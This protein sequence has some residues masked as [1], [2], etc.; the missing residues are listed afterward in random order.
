V[1]DGL[2]EVAVWYRRSFGAV[3]G[4]QWAATPSMQ[5]LPRAVHHTIAAG[6]YRDVDMVNAQPTLLAQYCERHGIPAPTLA[7]YASSR[8]TMLADLG[9][10]R[11]IGKRAVIALLN[12]GTRDV[13][14]LPR[15]PEW[16]RALKAEVAVIHNAMIAET[17]HR[18]VVAAARAR[19]AARGSGN[20]GGSVLSAVMMEIEDAVLM[21]MVARLRK[22]GMPIS[23]LVL[24]YD[25]FMLPTDAASVDM[26]FLEDLAGGA[27]AATGWRVRLI[28]K[29]MDEA[30][31]LA[32][33][34]HMAEDVAWAVAPDTVHGPS[35]QMQLSAA[36]QAQ[37][38]IVVAKPRAGPSVA[39]AGM[40]TADHL[41][42][43][44]PDAAAVAR[45]AC[46]E[47]ALCEVLADAARPVR[48]FFRLAFPTAHAPASEVVRQ[49]LGGVVAPRLT[50][51]TG[52]APRAQVAIAH[53][54]VSTAVRIVLDV[55]V[56]SLVECYRL[57]SRLQD[58]ALALREQLPALRMAGWA[59]RTPL[60]MSV[61]A[62]SVQLPVLGSRDCATAQV[63][64]A[65]NDGVAASSVDVGDHLVTT[66]A[67]R[68]PLVAGNGEPPAAAGATK[69][70]HRVVAAESMRPF[71][72]AERAE[73]AAFLNTWRVLPTV[74]GGPV[75]VSD[76]SSVNEAA[77]SGAREL[78][79]SFRRRGRGPRGAARGGRCQAIGARDVRP[80]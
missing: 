4:R 47:S 61:Y 56:A 17:R 33:I 41:F 44:L 52:S 72:G 20:L 14:A 31:D 73:Y 39:G 22:L 59:A 67:L 64:T 65:Y 13:A 57:C 12:G 45:V 34:A 55:R 74:F 23:G 77:H 16:L 75:E 42:A 60:D 27:E 2:G 10:S 36:R 29:P 11:D 6:L 25:G 19:A 78:G 7:R 63:L 50:P 66:A 58:D 21:A 26:A 70:R 18:D 37:A 9:V 80:P 53:S 15:R 40:C 5:G 69:R 43:C 32:G 71:S 68:F 62:E 79:V 35:G 51:L 3:T 24:V 28:E 54:S 48:V 49:F 46:S 30:I 38:G 1:G 76:V 8:D